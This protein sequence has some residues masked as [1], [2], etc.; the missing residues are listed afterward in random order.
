MGGPA[1]PVAAVKRAAY[2][3]PGLPRAVRMKGEVGR[4]RVRIERDGGTREVTERD[5]GDG[6]DG[7]GGV[8]SVDM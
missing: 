1:R 5:G 2:L 4:V 8:D 6:G 7:L 3:R